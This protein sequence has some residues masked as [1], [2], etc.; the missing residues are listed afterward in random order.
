MESLNTNSQKNKSKEKPPIHDTTS[1]GRPQMKDNNDDNEFATTPLKASFTVESDTSNDRD[2]KATGAASTQSSS[3]P[4][5][6]PSGSADKVD[7]ESLVSAT[8][9][10]QKLESKMDDL[11]NLIYKA[12]EKIQRLGEA[13]CRIGDKVENLPKINN[14]KTH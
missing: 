5:A 6:A 8:K 10:E 3:S 14:R 4:S 13:L 2:K 11:A 12:G 7:E 1:A 9:I